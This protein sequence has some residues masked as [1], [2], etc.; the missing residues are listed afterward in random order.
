MTGSCRPGA[1]ATPPAAHRN[2]RC[3]GSAPD[4]AGLRAACQGAS[5]QKH[6]LLRL[7]RISGRRYHGQL[8][9]STKH[10]GGAR[11][12]NGWQHKD[13]CIENQC[14]CCRS[15]CPHNRGRTACTDMHTHHLHEPHLELPR[16]HLLRLREHLLAA[17][18]A[19]AL[20]LQVCHGS[21]GSPI[22]E[23]LLNAQFHSS[24]Q[25]IVRFKKQAGVDNWICRDKRG[26][27]TR[28]AALAAR[29]HLHHALYNVPSMMLAR[30]SPTSVSTCALSSAELY[31]ISTERGAIRVRVNF[32]GKSS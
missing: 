25:R 19:A 3:S 8:C 9:P 11:R 4:K 18:A 23:P 22:I 17:A 21:G 1:P 16:P 6:P 28:A 20:L 29:N 32:A 13:T 31:S 14:L 7:A 15:L 24:T 12:P 2:G 5:E 26:S 27:C 30:D 10:V